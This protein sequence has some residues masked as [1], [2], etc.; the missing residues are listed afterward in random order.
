TNGILTLGT[1]ISDDISGCPQ[2]L[3]LIEALK[4]VKNDLAMTISEKTMYVTSG[5]F[6]AAIPCVELDQIQIDAFDENVYEIS[7]IVG[8]CL[9]FL[10]PLVD[11]NSPVAHY[12]AVFVKSGSAVSTNGH[13]L[14]EHWHGY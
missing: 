14:L 1:K 8:D 11:P 2:T 12:A 6:R 4:S 7:P 10:H 5:D 3:L 9:K 13:I